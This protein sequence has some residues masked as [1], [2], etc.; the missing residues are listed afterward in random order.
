M[1]D[2]SVNDATAILTD[3]NESEVATSQHHHKQ[4][5]KAKKSTK[6]SSSAAASSSSKR[7]SNRQKSK[8][9]AS[10]CDAKPSTSTTKKTPK[11]RHHHTHEDNDNDD[12]DF[13][14][15]E[16]IEKEPSRKATSRQA[17]SSIAIAV[18]EATSLPPSPRL[19]TT[20]ARDLRKLIKDTF[21]YSLKDTDIR[22]VEELYRQLPILIGAWDR[23]GFNETTKNER[24]EKFYDNITERLED[25]VDGEEDLEEKILDDIKC[26]MAT[27]KTLC[28]DLQIKNAEDPKNKP[29]NFKPRTIMDEEAYLRK[30][31]KRLEAEK[32]IRVNNFK[33]LAL[34]ESNLC[35][36]LKMVR[37]QMTKNIP[38]EADIARLATRIEEMERE[39]VQRLAKMTEYKEKCICYN[40]DLDVSQSDSFA[41]QIL[42]EEPATMSLGDKDLGRAS[43]F[44]EE[45]RRKHDA[46]QDEIRTLRGKIKELWEKLKIDNINL[47]EVVY[48]N[49]SNNVSK[50]KP[51]LIF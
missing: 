18:D 31:V 45:L 11:N 25:L 16:P 37:T 4:V 8:T 21:D 9:T 33:K 39:R 2:S 6:S 5:S 46:A 19:N 17:K 13:V 50:S 35:E 42:F 10:N 20:Q 44:L 15:E 47:K 23:I 30:E 24:L 3:Q 34:I 43:E 51:F 49:S 36:T 48:N 22:F 1:N 7:S 29:A 14:E 28:F 27:I 40:N 41:E 12:D 38:S 32:T 26:Q